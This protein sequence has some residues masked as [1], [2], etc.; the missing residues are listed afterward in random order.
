MAR[1]GRIIV[2]LV[3]IVIV[4]GIGFWAW[5][6]EPA[7]DPVSRPAAGQFSKASIAKGAELAALGNCQACHTRPNGKAYAGGY[8]VETPFGTIYGSNITPDPDTGIG[9]W[10]EAAFR[11]S[12]HEGLRRDGGHLYPAF[13]YTH[14]TKVSDADIKDIYAF[15]M[16]RPAVHNTVPSPDLPFPLDIRMVMAG[17]NLLFFHEGR[18]QPDGSQNAA[19]NH[20]AYIAEGLG[21]CAACHVPMNMFGAE[22]TDKGYAG[23]NAAG[24]HAPALDKSSPSPVGWTKDELAGY[25]RG[26]MTPH[27]GVAAG[28]MADVTKVLAEVPHADVEALSTYILSKGATKPA[29]ARKAAIADAGKKSFQVTTAQKANFKGSAKDGEAIFAGACASCHFD[30][31]S[32]PFYRPVD[33]SLSSAVNAPNA[34]NLVQII[35]HGVKPAA[36]GSGPIMPGFG[37][38]LTD[39]QTASLVGYVRKHFT[40]KPAWDHVDKAISTSK[41]TAGQ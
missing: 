11:R 4:V 39:D 18:Y 20:G 19:W 15:L 34:T 24:W 33:L 30:G 3:A 6:S 8:P 25:L 28:P 12:M 17:W 1:F 41:E 14:F 35:T 2:G 29:D 21:H 27:H 37:D 36:G 23:G 38:V 10:S 7:I 26:D 13:P 40:G 9:K 16:T 32:Q 5:A 22:K 31:G